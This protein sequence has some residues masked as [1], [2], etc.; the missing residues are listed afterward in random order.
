[1]T[2][3]RVVQT[4]A[5]LHAFVELPYALYRDS[6]H[7]VPPLRMLV[8]DLLNRE[9]HPFYRRAEA[10]YFL[11]E[12]DGRLVGRVAVIK[13]DAYIEHSGRKAAFFGFFECENDPEVASWMFRVVADWAKTRGLDTLIG[14]MSPN[15]MGEM[16]FLVDGFDKDPA[17]LMPYNF[18]YYDSLVTTCGFTKEVDLL[19]YTIDRQ[20]VNIDHLERGN[21]LVRRRYPTLAVRA[22]SKRD[23]TNDAVIIADIFNRAWSRNWG[24]APLSKEEFAHLAADLKLLIDFNFA[25]IAEDE[26]KPV[27][28]CISLPDFNPILKRMNGNLFPFGIFRLLFG[29]KQITTLRTVLMGVLPEYQGKGVDSFVTLEGIRNGLALGYQDA[30]FSWLLETNTSMINLA[31]RLGA[32]L[33]KRYRTYKKLL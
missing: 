15:M 30:E 20:S 1:M 22:V 16:G 19:A 21:A 29:R 18:P 10:D 27:A 4:K 7:F 17:I 6:P 23:F 26:G 14:P 13:S 28:F 5:D 9:K 8:K 25:H 11:A 2:G 31:E 3:V 12:K 33:D 32:R 24:F